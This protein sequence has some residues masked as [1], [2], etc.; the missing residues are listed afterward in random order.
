MFLFFNDEKN[1][2]RPKKK[3][4]DNARQDKISALTTFDTFTTAHKSD[5]NTVD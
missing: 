5:M 4:A 3:N 1:A 2:F